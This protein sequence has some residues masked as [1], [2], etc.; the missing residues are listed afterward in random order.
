L[1]SIIVACGLLFTSSAAF[2]SDSINWTGF[3]VGAF[4]ARTSLDVRSEASARP[5][6]IGPGIG[7]E[8][9]ADAM[10]KA[11]TYSQREKDVNI[12]PGLYAGYQWQYGSFVVGLE[13]DLQRGG[14]LEQTGANRVRLVGFTNVQNYE[15][16]HQFELDHVSTLRGRLGYADKNWL[17]YV[18][19]GLA[20]GRVSSSLESYAPFDGPSSPRPISPH[21]NSYD[22]F[23]KTGWTVGLGGEVSLSS[24]IRLRTE[25]IHYDLG[26][27]QPLSQSM[28]S[29]PS[30]VIFASAVGEVDSKLSGTAI[31]VG[32][33]Y[34][35]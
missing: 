25:I 13:A 12:N 1:K 23:S 28:I 32:L 5:W 30:G 4:G 2:G 26:S 7:S 8:Q 27:I 21:H 14:S 18:T 22:A 31:R 34:A 24:R 33:N 11:M 19:G 20:H 15:Y 6:V 29:Y 17:V 10:V 9:A 3:Y 16:A 35:F